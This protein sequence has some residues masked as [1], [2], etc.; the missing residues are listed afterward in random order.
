MS[1]SDRSRHYAWIVVALLVPVAL[2]NYLDRQMLATMK[3]SMVGD[4]PSI[5]D[6]ADWGLILGSFKWTYALLGPVAGYIADRFSRRW[7]IGASLFLWSVVTWWTG[8]CTTFTE[9]LTARAFMGI[10]EAFY[11]PAALALITEYHLGPTRSRAIGV[12]HAGVYLGQILGGFAGY[13][14]DSPDHG[15]RWAFSTSG[16]LGALYAI[17][18]L[19]LLR[20][21]VR[22]KD[23]D[24]APRA[25]TGVVRGLL[26]NRNFLLLVMYFT[27]PAI[28][29]WIV[30]DWMPEILRERFNLGQ[31]KAGVSAILFVQVASLVGALVGGTLA[32]RWMR[33][34]PRGRI[35]ASAI[36]TLLFLP[37]LF[38]V[39]NAGTLGVAIAGLIVFGLGWGFFD[40]NNMPILSQIARPEWRATGYGLM[41]LVS[42]S[43]G[44]FGDW[45]FGALRDRHVPL[46]LIFGVFAGVALLSVAIVLMIRVRRDGVI[47][48]QSVTP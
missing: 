13:A 42:I 25:T 41:N 3:A 35:Y 45:A 8:H 46:N 39:G 19:V 17:P 28:A 4:I 22:F 9:L 38:S 29:G 23:D 40:S 37:A 12:H 47:A 6:K 21:P 43:F 14:A 33:R 16:M 30:R 10:S 2:L 31:G 27:L 26:G 24:G 44:G 15:W 20:D 36:G 5:A 34:T 32:D 7:V 48:E 11:F 1:S 18:L